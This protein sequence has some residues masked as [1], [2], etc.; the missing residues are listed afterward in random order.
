VL[1]GGCSPL[2]AVGEDRGHS[3]V[4]AHC[5]AIS[6]I[7]PGALEKSRISTRRFDKHGDEAV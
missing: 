5:S 6:Q 1:G 2:G 3:L 7:D 4:V